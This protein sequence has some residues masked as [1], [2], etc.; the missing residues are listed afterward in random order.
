MGHIHM[1]LMQ[2]GGSLVLS[3][4]G[5]TVSINTDGPENMAIFRKDGSVDLFYNNSKKFETTS[6]GIDVTGTVTSDGLTVDG[7]TPGTT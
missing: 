3:T 1:L 6:T 7:S 2:G 4:N 5:S